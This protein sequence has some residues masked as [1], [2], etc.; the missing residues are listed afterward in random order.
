MKMLIFHVD[1][2]GRA[3]SIE[4]ARRGAAVVVNDLANPDKVVNEILAFGGKAV[5]SKASVEDG[6]AIIKTGK[7]W[8]V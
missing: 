7:P 1:R 3:Y 5:G 4:L 8:T 6:A 2:L